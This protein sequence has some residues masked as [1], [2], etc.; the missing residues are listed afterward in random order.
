MESLSIYNPGALIPAKSTFPNL[1]K[2]VALLQ[3]EQIKVATSQMIATID[4]PTAVESGTQ[5]TKALASPA[6]AD[7]VKKQLSAMLNDVALFFGGSET[8]NNLARQNLATSIIEQYGN[9]NV[10]EIALAIQYGK[11]G[12]FGRDGMVFGALKASDILKW[13]TM[14]SASDEKLMYWERQ[15]MQQP[16]QPEN[17]LD[18]LGA[19]V[20]NGRI[21]LPLQKPQGNNDM[22]QPAPGSPAW[23]RAEADRLEALENHKRQEREKQLQAGKAKG[24]MLLDGLAQKEAFKAFAKERYYD[25]LTKREQGILASAEHGPVA[26]TDIKKLAEL[27]ERW[28]VLLTEWENRP[29]F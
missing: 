29:L 11:A 27:N 3:P 12:K 21:V 5:L 25:K 18:L 17:V 9:L 20:Q 10:E 26:A 15:N 4:V 13:L 14:Y 23:H 1:S 2:E 8:F 7:G 16:Q 24:Q 28:Q 6:L 22:Q 19:S